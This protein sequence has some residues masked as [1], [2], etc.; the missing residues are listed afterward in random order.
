MS[1]QI[2]K[3]DVRCPCCF[4]LMCIRDL[5]H[6]T[7]FQRSMTSRKIMTDCLTN[8]TIHPLET[9]HTQSRPATLKQAYESI[10]SVQTCYTQC[11]AFIVIQSSKDRISGS[12]HNP[13]SCCKLES[14]VVDLLTIGGLGMRAQH[15]GAVVN[16]EECICS[17]YIR[18]RQLAIYQFSR[19]L[20]E[21]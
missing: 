2:A 17:F 1:R 10:S 19:V 4:G 20:R 21:R 7:F 6:N 3:M 8:N 5:C 16:I 9:P 11:P 18:T 15:N 13:W 12:V 14:L